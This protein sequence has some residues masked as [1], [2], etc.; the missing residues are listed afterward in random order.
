[1][2]GVKCTVQIKYLTKINERKGI[3]PFLWLTGQCT[4]NT[5]L[6]FH[7]RG[8]I[9]KESLFSYLYVDDQH[10]VF[11]LVFS[12]RMQDNLVS[13]NNLMRLR[14]YESQGRRL[15]CY[16]CDFVSTSFLHLITRATFKNVWKLWMRAFTIDNRYR[17]FVFDKVLQL[18]ETG[19]T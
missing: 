5:F 12:F 14:C 8:F 11:R 13:R 3:S 18:R 17:C 16:K 1:M 7:L 9:K 15:P 2:L 6:Y 4:L 19:M 10:S